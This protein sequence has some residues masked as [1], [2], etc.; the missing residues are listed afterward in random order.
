MGLAHIQA[1]RGQ[2]TGQQIV[3]AKSGVARLRRDEPGAAAS[4]E[5]S[6]ASIK[7]KGSIA[8]SFSNES[9][10][11]A[12]KFRTP[13]G[14][15]GG[16]D[17]SDESMEKGGGAIVDGLS[18]PRKQR[19]REITI[20]KEELLGRY[21]RLLDENGALK[22]ENA[23]LRRELEGMGRDNLPPPPPSTPGPLVRSPV[24]GPMRRRAEE[25][26]EKEKEPTRPS[27]RDRTARRARTR[28][29]EPPTPI[30]R[31]EVMR[32]LPELLEELIPAILAK[33]GMIPP[34][35]SAGKR[36]PPPKEGRGWGERGKMAKA[37]SPPS[38]TPSKG[39]RRPRWSGEE[40]VASPAKQ[41]AMREGGPSLPRQ[42][43]RQQRSAQAPPSSTDNYAR[44]LGRRERAKAAQTAKATQAAK[45]PQ[46][47][48]KGP[49]KPAPSNA[50]K[51]RRP[52]KNAAITVTCSRGEYARVM[53]EA[54]GK[55]DLGGLGIGE[56]KFGTARTGATLLEVPGPDSSKKAD[57][58]AEAHRKAFQGKEG[59]RV[60][61][62][63]KMG[64]L[65]I[66][67]L[68]ISIDSNEVAEAVAEVGGSPLPRVRVGLIRLSQGGNG[69]GVVCVRCPLDAAIKVVAGG[70]RIKV[71]GWATVGVS[72]LEERPL[73]CF[74]CLGK[75][76]VRVNC[77]SPS[78]RS[79][80]CYRCGS[81][82]HI[83]RDCEAPASC[84]VCRD[85]GLPHAHRV[86]GP[87]CKA[88]SS[89]GRMGRGVVVGTASAPVPT[90]KPA[91]SPEKKVGTE[92]KEGKGVAL[93]PTSSPEVMDV[94][95]AGTPDAV[96]L[97]SASGPADL[98]REKVGQA[99]VALDPTSAPAGER[100]EEADVA[101]AVSTPTPVREPAVNAAIE[102]DETLWIPPKEERP[103]GDFERR[104][105]GRAEPTPA[106]ESAV[107]DLEDSV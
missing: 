73:Q 62:P 23:R 87:A 40:S 69:M 17:I 83:A 88:P 56:I 103:R 14:K 96:A 46:G 94:E 48:E 79:G 58:L 50:P 21:G 33:M 38:A 10:E 70:G 65:R 66:R 8:F 54:R 106:E 61:R 76:H 43:Q 90:P 82:G 97:N 24:L 99:G 105:G 34:I 27:A 22:E 86:G 28:R 68:H 102:E 95:E 67:D 81:T 49:T 11:E 31:E 5:S 32:R 16:G 85:K 57:A 2:T 3:A 20:P 92:M 6:P 93:A 25:E 100:K 55:I 19:R 13:R 71:G 12:D 63:I 9:G 42:Q 44:V 41:L 72:L 51:T 29:R 45:K 15:M 89:R 80:A 52:P 59:V 36:V 78:D 7:R 104:G 77:T 26:K 91:K 47:K 35:P 64:E 75:G 53:R 37:D 4:R 60:E 98:I 107:G 1:E 18:R 30:T 101:G 39:A 74:R 84:P